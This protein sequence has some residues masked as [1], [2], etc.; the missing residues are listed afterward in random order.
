MADSK[1]GRSNR[2]TQIIQHVFERRF[3][4]GD[5]EVAF[6][7][8]DFELAAN[9]L[10]L[11]VLRNLGDVVYSFRYRIPLPESITSLAPAGREW[12]IFPAGKGVYCFRLAPFGLVLPR[13]GLDMIKVPDATPGL[14]ARYATSDEQA[15]LA[16]VRYNRLLDIFTGVACY[17][18]QSHMRTT[19]EVDNPLSGALDKSQVETDE[20]YLGIDR[21]GAHHIFPVQAKGGSDAISVVQIWQDFR[22]ATQKFPGLI[23]RPVAAQFDAEDVI[24]LFEF[25]EGDGGIVIV[26]ER[27]F[28]L[29]N[30][31]EL[32]SE[33]LQCYRDVA[34]RFH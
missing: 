20:L 13:S 9:S 6:T 5:E 1:T 8:A 28:Q 21:Y 22:V 24:V 27:R 29:V 30:E 25:R 2:Y 4:P 32:T 31:D 16:R 17:S 15:L 19:I 34:Q 7:R 18:L 3:R 14:I 11:E 23:P 12:V 10:A 26:Q 33:E